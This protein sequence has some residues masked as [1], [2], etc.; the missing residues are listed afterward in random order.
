MDKFIFKQENK[1]ILAR[2]KEVQQVRITTGQE[3]KRN[4]TSLS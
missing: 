2:V 4:S 1:A 3:E